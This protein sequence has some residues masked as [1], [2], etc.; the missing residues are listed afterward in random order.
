MRA[1][2]SRVA[3]A[4]V[5]LPLLVL[6]AAAHH[7]DH[8]LSV[9]SPHCGWIEGDSLRDRRNLEDFCERSVSGDL[10]I[11]SAGADRERLWIEAPAGLV[12]SM[13]D[14]DRSTA[15]LLRAWLREWRTVSG[16]P[17]AAVSLMRNH[18]EVAAVRTS[19]AGDVVSFR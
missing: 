1:I 13:R 7:G 11:M 6:P 15:A 8:A 19:M 12:S 16:Y 2:F 3:A 18:V 5:S 17:S 4:A 9:H 14:D 10:R